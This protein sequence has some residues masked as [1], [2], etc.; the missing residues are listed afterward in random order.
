MC[1][2]IFNDRSELAQLKWLCWSGKFM[3]IFRWRI[4]IDYDW[5]HTFFAWRIQKI[6]ENKG[7]HSQVTHSSAYFNGEKNVCTSLCHSQWVRLNFEMLF[8]TGATIFN[9]KHI[10]NVDG[11][12]RSSHHLRATNSNP[13]RDEKKTVPHVKISTLLLK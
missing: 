10:R 12:N 11:S 8:S 4:C 3:A 5:A 9:K 6:R 13:L 1:H 2:I 7:I